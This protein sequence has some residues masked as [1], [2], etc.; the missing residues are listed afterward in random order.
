MTTT[1]RRGRRAVVAASL[2][3]AVAAAGLA[4]AMP[5]QAAASTLA[6]AAQQS[7]RYFGT[8][9]AAGRLNDSTYQTIANREFDMITAE[10]EMK[11]DATEPNRGQFNYSNGDRIVN[12]ARQNGKQVRG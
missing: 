10:N 11:M 8:A 3:L 12:W 5:A 1:P 7:G 9:I 2:T 6:A 4:A